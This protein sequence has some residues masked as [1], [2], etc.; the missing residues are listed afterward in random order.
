VNNLLIPRKEIKSEIDPLWSIEIKRQNVDV[1]KVFEEEVIFE[2]NMSISIKPLQYAPI[3]VCLVVG[4]YIME[5]IFPL[6]FS[7]T[8]TKTSVLHQAIMKTL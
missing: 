5:K 1:C 6:S 2:A 3:F 7:D 8:T 4:I